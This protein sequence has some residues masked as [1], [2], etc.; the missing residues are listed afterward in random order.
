MV[1]SNGALSIVP[2]VE[3]VIHT[4]YTIDIRF[5]SGLTCDVFKSKHS[6]FDGI[7]SNY[8]DNSMR[9]HIRK[10]TDLPKE[11]QQMV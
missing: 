11:R 3:Y 5:I 2:G 10:R 9:S 8:F 4:T 1:W 6:I 7:L